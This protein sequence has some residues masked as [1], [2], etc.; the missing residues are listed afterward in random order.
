MFREIKRIYL[1]HKRVVCAPLRNQVDFEN[2]KYT[3]KERIMIDDEIEWDDKQQ[4]RN[5]R[6]VDAILNK[7]P[8]QS[9]S[10]SYPGIWYSVGCGLAVYTLLRIFIL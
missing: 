1:Y 7:A 9:S 3:D 8:A 6:F 5:K 4:T 10:Y 2:G